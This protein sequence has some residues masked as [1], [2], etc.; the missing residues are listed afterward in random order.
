MLAALALTGVACSNN[1]TAPNSAATSVVSVSPQGGA[2]NVSTGTSVM[3]TFSRAMRPAMQQY[4]AL[5]RDSLRGPLV[6]VTM[7]WSADS[8]MLTM[9]PSAPLAAGTHYVLHMGG[10]M[11]DAR[12]DSI[13]YSN[14]PGFGG[15]W[16]TSSMMGGGMMGG[17]SEM[18]SGWMGGNGDYGMEF[19]FTTN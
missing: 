1:T 9:M 7:S 16:V 18:G 15:Q 11:L 3:A 5:H 17:G 6:S 13:N 4:M 10:G 12:G 8:T 19:P 2:T 14:C